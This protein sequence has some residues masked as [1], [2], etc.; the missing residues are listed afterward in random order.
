MAGL[1]G[2]SAGHEESEPPVERRRALARRRLEA[3]FAGVERAVHG[4]ADRRLLALR[5]GEREEPAVSSRE[6][7]GRRRRARRAGRVAGA[8]ACGG[9]PRAAAPC[10]TPWAPWWS[11]SPGATAYLRTKSGVSGKRRPNPKF[12]PNEPTH[13][14]R[15]GV[16]GAGAPSSPRPKSTIPSSVSVGFSTR[17]CGNSGLTP[18]ARV[19]LSFCID[20]SRDADAPAAAPARGKSLAFFGPRF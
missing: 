12:R 17:S 18:R 8:V 5:A 4:D 20:T 9:A 7:G 1:S 16:S 6:R 15:G 10:T 2:S 3:P 13:N 11:R 14:S 19:H